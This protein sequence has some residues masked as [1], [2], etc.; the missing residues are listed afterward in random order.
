MMPSLILCIGQTA[1]DIGRK[2]LRRSITATANREC[3]DR[4]SCYTEDVM[5]TKLPK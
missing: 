2:T 1:N 5:L 4:E 3:D